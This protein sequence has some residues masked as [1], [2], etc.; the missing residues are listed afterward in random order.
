MSKVDRWAPLGARLAS[1]E[2][3]RIG[4]DAPSIEFDDARPHPPRRPYSGPNPFKKGSGFNLTEQMRIHRENPA[5]A[6]ALKEA[7]SA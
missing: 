3:V 5:L 2:K 1:G 7:A 4:E 6:A